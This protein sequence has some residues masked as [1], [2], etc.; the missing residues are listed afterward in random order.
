MRRKRESAES[1][2][3][4]KENG[5]LPQ[6]AWRSILC[7]QYFQDIQYIQGIQYIQ[8]IQGIQD[9]LDIEMFIKHAI[10]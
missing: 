5:V 8:N 1:A 6:A 2:A 7:S 4:G 10:H 9:V 3:A